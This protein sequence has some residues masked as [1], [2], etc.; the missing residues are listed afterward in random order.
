MTSHRKKR[1]ASTL[2]SELDGIDGIGAVKK[3]ALLNYFGSV[4]NIVNANVGEL[5]K[6]DGIN[7]ALARKI[8]ASFH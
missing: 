5:V 3:R 2:K 8:Y 4:K 7:A 6:V 1:A